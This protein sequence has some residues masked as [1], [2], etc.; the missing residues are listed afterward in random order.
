MRTWDSIQ[1]LL[2]QKLLEDR[3]GIE[4]LCRDLHLGVGSYYRFIRREGGLTSGAIDRLMKEYNIVAVE[5]P[6]HRKR[7]R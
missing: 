7:S 1:D 4:R 5:R 3:R 6:R 2:R